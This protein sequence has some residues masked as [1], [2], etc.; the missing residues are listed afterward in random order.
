[1]MKLR[2]RQVGY[3]MQRSYERRALKGFDW[4]VHVF[5]RISFGVGLDLGLRLL[6]WKDSKGSNSRTNV[7]PRRNVAP[8]RRLHE[9]RV[10][11]SVA[12]WLKLRLARPDLRGGGKLGSCQGASTTKGLPQKIWIY[13]VI[14]YVYSP[15]RQKTRQT[16]RQY[17]VLKHNIII[18]QRLWHT[19]AASYQI[20]LIRN[21]LIQHNAKHLKTACANHK[22]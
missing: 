22:L 4:E 19:H 15:N 10:T 8:V 1:M 9:D 12:Q 17:K 16:E 7:K 2:T 13:L 6:P 18:I 3:R 20:K 14:E 5:W 11:R 21:G